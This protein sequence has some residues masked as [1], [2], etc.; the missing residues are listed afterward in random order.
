MELI[1]DFNTGSTETDNQDLGLSIIPVN[2]NKSPFK[3]WTRFQ[4][5]IPGIEDWHRHY[6][7][8][9]T[10]GIITGRISGN[11]ECLDIDVKNDPLKT[12]MTEFSD[13]IPDALLS[14]LLI[15]STP[16][17]G[18]HIIYRC[19]EADIDGN[20]K[21]AQ[22]SDK[23]V[24]IETRG[25]AGYFC[26]SRT[27]NDLLQGVFN[28]ETLDVSIPEISA[29]ER[30]FLLETARSLTRHFPQN[31]RTK[32]EFTYSEPAINEFN[33]EYSILELFERHNWSVVKEDLE[34]V[35]LLRAGSNAQH[36]G[37]YFKTAKTFYC[38]STSTGFKP[39][40][41]YNHFQVL[42]VL[43]GRD[44]YR[45]TKRL[46]PKLGFDVTEKKNRVSAE[47]IAEYLNAKGVRYDSFIQD[48]TLNGKIIEELD[49]NTVF[50][51]LKKH[52]DKEIPRTRFEE[53]IKSH[54]IQASN[55][56][57]DFIAAHQDRSPEGSFEAWLDCLVLQNQNIDK[58]FVV[59]FLKKWYVGMIAMAL[60]GEFPNEF[61][62]TLISVE[63]G[64]GKTTFLRN[65]TLP[66]DLQAYQKEHALS[67][68]EDFKVLMSQALLIVDDE[69]DSRT[70]ESDKT[71][72]TLL[73]T[74]ELTTRRKYDRR[75]STMKRRS[76]FAGSGNNLNVVRESQNRRIIPLEIHGMHFDKLDELDLVDL[77]MEAYRL[78]E[79]GFCYSY[80]RQDKKLLES[81]YAD[82]IQ[83]SDVD[84]ILD[85]YLLLPET[86]DDMFSITN[87]DLV[88]SLSTRF[89]AFSKRLNV[90]TI[91]K[92]MAERG[93]ETARKGPNRL[94]C[95]VISK[96]SKVLELLEN[97]SQSWQLM[98]EP[99]VD[100]VCKNNKI[101]N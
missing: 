20:Q 39:D 24:I 59:H 47:S 61:F 51:D 29:D 41:A 96:H 62:L 74:K 53:T 64:I 46:L 75:I 27:S 37:Y 42:Q 36:S 66:K 23:A 40:R 81:L 13:R 4:K 94:S 10:V 60:D 90:P 14:R 69:M 58:E 101:K 48:L 26:T 3:A 79:N 52:F 31:Q 68:D 2:S 56:V 15:Q 6:V 50:I 95:Y 32:K 1:W 28:L 54:Y 71:F 63:Q 99:F 25:E 30:D 44:D 57:R 78:F 100:R 86:Q 84:L 55:P 70:Y 77:F 34:K 9:G 91:G 67:S 19:P 8:Q 17:N 93:F 5:E 43:E 16:N 11:L 33:Q 49:Y 82:Y 80:Q 87:L 76:S 83:K 7:N 97:D 45:T 98:A 89:P 38:F 88:N 35:Y 73:S 65:Y 72:K 21:L 18:F 92:M 22:H 12:I 85:E